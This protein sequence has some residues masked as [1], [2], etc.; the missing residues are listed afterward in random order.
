MFLLDP[1]AFDSLPLVL[2]CLSVVGVVVPDGFCE[3][4]WDSV[5]SGMESRRSSSCARGREMRD[6]VFD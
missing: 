2:M 1:F 3:S 6:S 5:S 4:H